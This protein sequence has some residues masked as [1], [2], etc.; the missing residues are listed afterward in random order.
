M[1][2]MHGPLLVVSVSR[3]ADGLPQQY[4]VACLQVR[5]EDR[6]QEAKAK[7]AAKAEPREV[8]QLGV[9]KAAHEHLLATQDGGCATCHV[10]KLGRLQ[11]KLYVDRSAVTGAARGLL[12]RKCKAVVAVFD[13]H[14]RRSQTDCRLPGTA[15][16]QRNGLVGPDWESLVSSVPTS[17]PSPGHRSLR[18]LSLGIRRQWVNGTQRDKSPVVMSGMAPRYGRTS[19]YLGV[20]SCTA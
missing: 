5:A 10:N 8:Q 9:T 14:T 16:F 7:A 3:R 20:S 11:P 4:C 19:A 12:C 1:L 2:L 6:R 15:S 13:L 17:A 18:L